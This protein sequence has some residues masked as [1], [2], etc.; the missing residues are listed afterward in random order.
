MSFKTENRK[1]S[2]IF[3]GQK[4]FFVPR[5]QR[6]YVWNTIIWSELL[7]DLK[8]TISDEEKKINWSHFVGT[9]VLNRKNNNSLGNEEFEIIDGQ[10]RLTTIF[11]IF[12]AICSRLYVLGEDD[13]ISFANNIINTYISLTKLDGGKQYKLSN[14]LLKS[15]FDFILQAAKDKT[16]VEG[17]SIIKSLY[18]FFVNEFSDYDF[19][20]IKLFFEKLLSINIVE[21]ISES[22]EEIYNIFEV[23]NARGQKLKQLELL[24]NRV[25]KYIYPR[26]DDVIDK[27]KEDWILI[28]TNLLDIKDADVF[29]LHFIKCYLKRKPDNKDMVYKIIKETIK[30]EK[31]SELLENLKKYSESYK[32][33]SI[34]N[35]KNHYIKYFDIKGNQQIR[36]ILAALHKKIL[37]DF[38][39]EA[40]YN[41]VL[42]EL[43]NFFFIYNLTQQTS[44][45]I[46]KTISEF[47]YKIYHTE[48]IVELKMIVSEMFYSLKKY[49]PEQIEF[50]KYLELYSNLKYS[51]KKESIFKRNSN[52]VKYVLYE[53]YMELQKDTQINYEELTIEHIYSD[54]GNEKTSRLSNLTLL[55]KAFNESLG[56]K[57]PDKK[58]ELI[59]LNSTITENKKLS[60]FIIEGEFNLEERTRWFGKKMQ[61]FLF[62][63]NVLNI[64]ESRIAEY[65]TNYEIVKDNK[66]L[67]KLLKT[68]G[69]N[70]ETN[71]KLNKK[72]DQYYQEFQNLKK[73][74]K[75]QSKKV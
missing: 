24:K 11:V 49:I 7:A 46:D 75:P 6:N 23:L 38:N 70:F 28:E 52:L 19:E 3:E 35:N 62:Q 68:N 25:M 64:N 61:L 42:K 67:L 29:L 27:V 45:K 22:D 33:I 58:I 21:I 14:D 72:L 17:K 1:I 5:Y 73:S 18:N 36:S 9:I 30:L 54:Q 50:D 53:I 71:L 74:Y 63:P 43:R 65:N 66:D 34:K 48:T 12:I 40:L 37:N 8:F 57:S 41:I 55:T 10:Q 16:R 69:Y 56:N 31:M 32:L 13:H 20:N 15:D 26:E 59:T 2:N 44:N 51:N 4:V 60:Q 39:D 47:A